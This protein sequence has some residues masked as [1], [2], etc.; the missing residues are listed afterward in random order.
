MQVLPERAVTPPRPLAASSSSSSTGSKKGPTLDDVVRLVAAQIRA[1]TRTA[2]PPAY[3][4]E[5]VRSF[6]PEAA[7]RTGARQKQSKT[8]WPVEKTVAVFQSELLELAGANI[9]HLNAE[10]GGDADSTWTEGGSTAST[11]PEYSAP[12]PGSVGVPSGAISGGGTPLDQLRMV[13]SRINIASYNRSNRSS[14]PNTIVVPVS[15]P[16]SLAIRDYSFSRVYCVALLE[17]FISDSDAFAERGEG[18][19]FYIGIEEL[20]TNFA[21][22]NDGSSAKGHFKCAAIPNDTDSSL[23]VE[24]LSHKI[25]FPDPVSTPGTFTF[26]LFDEQKLPLE[27][28]Q[29]VYSIGTIALDGVNER[30]LF[31]LPSHDFRNGDRVLFRGISCTTDMN[32]FA[33]SHKYRAQVIDTNTVAVGVWKTGLVVGDIVIEGAYIV[34]LNNSVR[35]SLDI[36]H[37]V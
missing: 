21:K 8:I 34:C 25:Q 15:T 30:I 26:R 37:E 35:L 10:V 36:A 32:L 2:V 29:D 18:T 19:P 31:T 9:S 14:S 11:R 3:L 17:V 13:H 24:I 7:A 28:E 1:K 27:L 23:R 22:Q 20:S 12:A 6:R 16:Q 5:Y 4:Y 33:D